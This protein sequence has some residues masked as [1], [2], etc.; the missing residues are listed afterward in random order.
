MTTVADRDVARRA[1]ELYEQRGREHGR[2]LDDWL[3]EERELRATVRSPS[4]E[5]DVRRLRNDSRRWRHRLPTTGG[6]WAGCK[7]F[8]TTQPVPTDGWS[9]I[10]A[11]LSAKRYLVMTDRGLAFCR[12][13]KRSWARSHPQL[14]RRSAVHGPEAD[15]G[16]RYSRVDAIPTLNRSLLVVLRRVIRTHGG[17]APTPISIRNSDRCSTGPLSLLRLRRASLMADE[18][19][20]AS[21]FRV[22]RGVWR[23]GRVNTRPLD[24]VLASLSALHVILLSACLVLGSMC[25]GSFF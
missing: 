3:Q 15:D 10:D 12:H 6:R 5:S 14:Q 9:S 1:Y 16:C 17:V 23:R 2:D 18:S 11:M 4:R 25:C 24:L 13:L 7:M 19:A 22:G 20:L 21:N 8:C